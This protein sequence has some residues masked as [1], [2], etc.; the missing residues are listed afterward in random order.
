MP[1]TASKEQENKIRRSSS[2]IMY[3]LNVT[4]KQKR[5]KDKEAL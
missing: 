3:N 4:K 2:R 1:L 5:K